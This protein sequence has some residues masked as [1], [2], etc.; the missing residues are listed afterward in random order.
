MSV[1]NPKNSWNMKLTR[2]PSRR[3]LDDVYSTTSASRCSQREPGL[4]SLVRCQRRREN[5]VSHVVTRL[6]YVAHGCLGVNTHTILACGRGK[7][8]RPLEGIVKNTVVF[9][10]TRTNQVVGHVYF[11]EER[12][13]RSGTIISALL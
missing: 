9:G 5:A 11:P 3:L 7:C 12:A 6:A 13:C 4:T 8:G 10:Y 1:Q 2:I